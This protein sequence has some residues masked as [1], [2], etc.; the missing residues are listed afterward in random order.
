MQALPAPNRAIHN[1]PIHLTSFIGREREIAE[2]RS[3]LSRQTA[4]QHDVRLLTLTGT[5]G[6][7]KTRLALQAAAGLLDAYSDGVW[8]VELAPSLDSTLVVPAIA[9]ALN[10]RETPGKHLL[11]S[12]KDFLRDKQLLL[13]LDNFEQVIMAAPLVGELLHHASHLKVLATSRELLRVYGEHDFPVSPLSLPDPQNLPP[14]ERLTQVEAVRLF[15][16]R[17]RAVKP[18]FSVTNENAPAVA[19]ICF[20]LDGLPLAVELAAARVRLLPPQKM[21]AQ[22]DNRLRFLTGGARDVPARQR[23]LRSTMDWSY[24][25]L[26]AHDKSLFRQLAVFAGGCTLEAAESVCKADG[27]YDVLN[28]LHSLMDQSLLKQRNPTA[29]RAS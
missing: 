7:G 21:L 5:G 27:R 3:L 4:S 6:C 20:R 22:L 19:E 23:T 14:L 29:S 9:Q 2:L 25:L 11:E 26:T 13:L 28:G 18:D 8:L 15:I 12:L 10:V 1:L 16:E 17:A 24:E